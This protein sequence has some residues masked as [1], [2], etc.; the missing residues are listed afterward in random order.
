MLFLPS[1]ALGSLTKGLAQA[2]LGIVV[3]LFGTWGAFALLEKVPSSGM[4]S[5][6]EGLGEITGTL[7]L[8]AIL[9]A[10][11]W[12]YARRKTWTSRGLLA[13]GLALPF[14]IAALTP[15]TSLVEKKHPLLEGTDAPVKITARTALPN[16]K[17]KS[18]LPDSLPQV[19]LSI[20]LAVSGVT[21][22]RLVRLDGMKVSFDTNGGAKWDSGWKGQ[23]QEIWPED[24]RKDV[25]FQI[26]RKDYERMKTQP[27]R[28]HI[29]LALTEF[30]EREARELVLPENK[31]ADGQ[32][33]FCRLNER[34]PSQIDCRR[35]F[36]YPS[37]MASFD[38]GTAKCQAEEN[39]DQIP[40]DKVTHVWFGPS[41][42]DSFS[43]LLN[44]VLDYPISFGSRTW[45]PATNG[46]AGRKQKVTHLCPG[47][48]VR[49]AKPEEKRRLRL[50]LAMD[51]VRLQDLSANAFNSD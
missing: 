47:A 34:T 25:L 38:P 20:P 16:P 24:E 51:A 36:Q 22:G 29:E 35:P 5:E 9:G 26:N 32:L 31:F 8:A 7:V 30:E 17:K 27:L 43:S 4:S 1:V 11:V 44:P 48:K 39:E 42:D 14:L 40:E 15:Y 13:G 46:A 2:L 33:G 21:P 23:Y 45:V 49:L 12:Q 10:A 3:I 37:L 18:I 41:S 50:K 19:Y 28:L 6:V